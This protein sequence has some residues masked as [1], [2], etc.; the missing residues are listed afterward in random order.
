MVAIYLIKR[1]YFVTLLNRTILDCY[2]MRKYCLHFAHNAGDIATW[3]TC[4]SFCEQLTVRFVCAR[5][6]TR[7][8]VND[9]HMYH[10]STDM[11]QKCSEQE[12]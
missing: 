6:I 3:N 8:S 2:Y 9:R 12:K 10:L 1:S 11:E 7:A 4:L 5:C